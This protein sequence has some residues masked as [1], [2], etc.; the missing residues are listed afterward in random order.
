MTPERLREIELL[1]HEARE[2]T[3]PERDAF[4]ARA[5]AQRGISLQYCMA[6]PFY[7]LP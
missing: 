3:P 2:R 6:N 4:L 1:F 5:C 7:F